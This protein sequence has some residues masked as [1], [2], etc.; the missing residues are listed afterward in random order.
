MIV[1][2]QDHSSEHEW[3][4]QI[5]MDTVGNATVQRGRQECLY[6]PTV[7]PTSHYPSYLAVPWDRPTQGDG[8]FFTQFID[9]NVLT[10]SAASQW[11]RLRASLY[12][13]VWMTMTPSILKLTELWERNNS[14]FTCRSTEICSWTSQSLWSPCGCK[15]PVGKAKKC[16]PKK[17]PQR[18]SQSI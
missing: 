11:R 9:W 17:S 3:C 10:Q 8:G 12:I 16:L 15:K 14:L 5:A 1:I 13:Q 7:P 4:V 18:Q 2:L 6:C